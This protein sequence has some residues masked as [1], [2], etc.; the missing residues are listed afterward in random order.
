MTS[1]TPVQCS[2]AEVV[3]LRHRLRVSYE[4]IMSWPV[5]SWLD[6]SVGRAL[7][8]YADVLWARHAIFLP[9]ERLLNSQGNTPCPLF[10]RVPITAADF[11]PKIGWRSG[12]NYSRGGNPHMKQTGTLVV[13]L[14][15][16]NFGFWSRLGYSGQRVPRRNVELREEKQKS[17]FVLNFH[18]R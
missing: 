3:Y 10:A 2:T 17:N 1:A 9:H 7:A 8:S 4:F 11:A 12:E 18:F 16:V 14:R 5:P 15:G 6:S 13:S